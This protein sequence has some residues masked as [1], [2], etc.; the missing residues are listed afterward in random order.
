[1]CILNKKSDGKLKA[2]A[3]LGQ[4]PEKSETSST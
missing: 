3:S 1:M 4:N 2:Y